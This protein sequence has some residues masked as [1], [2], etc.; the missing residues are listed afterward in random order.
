MTSWVTSLMILEPIHDSSPSLLSGGT[1]RFSNIADEKEFNLSRWRP[2]RGE[3]I[4]HIGH[5]NDLGDTDDL[6]DMGV[7]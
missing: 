5:L 7:V 1:W 2:T 6:D 3:S 4:G